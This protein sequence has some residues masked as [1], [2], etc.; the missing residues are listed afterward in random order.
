MNPFITQLKIKWKGRNAPAS[1]APGTASPPTFDKVRAGLMLL[2]I[3]ALSLMMSVH[4]RQDRAALELN[5]PSPREVRASR[6]V[7]YADSDKTTSLKQVAMDAARPVYDVDEHAAT[8]AH[9]TVQEIFGSLEATRSTLAQRAVPKSTSAR[10]NTRINN[11]TQVLPS[12]QSASGLPETYLRRLLTVPPTVFQRLRDTTTRLVDEAMDREIRDKPGE[13]T[14]A[15]QSVLRRAQET[16]SASQDARIVCAIANQALRPNH[17]LNRSKTQ[18]ARLAAASIVPRAYGRLFPGDKVIGLGETVHQDTLDKMTALGL[19]DPRQE[20]TTGF[21]ICLLAA[22]M[23]LLVAYYIAH[24]L[25]AL[26]QD[27]RRLALLS[28]IVMFSVAGLKIGASLL[29]LEFSGW[30]LGYLGMM[31]VTAAGML[32]SVLLDM[33][34]AMLIVALLS[35]QSGI[36]M[37]HEIRFSVMTLLSSLVGIASVTNV[38]VKNNLLSATAA[39]ALSN[40]GLVWLL[41]MLFNDRPAELLTG[42]AW[43]IGVAPFATFLFWFGVLALEKPFGILTHTALLEMSAFDRPLLKQLCAI[44]PGTYAHSMMVGTLAEAGAQAVGADA[45]L[46]RVGGYYHDIGKM[47]RPDFFIENQRAE[48]VHGRLSPS[49]SAL[50]I[51]AHVRD[52]IEMAKQHR[53]PAEIRDMI[54]QH[55][56]TTLISYFYR[57]ALADNGCGDCAPPGMEERFRYPGPKPQTRESAIV[58]L[59]DS[60]EAAARCIDKPNQEKLE[61]L[62]AG[63]VR[64]KIE[65]G[66]LDQ[67]ALTFADVK[68]ISNAFLHVLRAMMHGRIDY[69][70]DPPRTATGKPME[71]SRADLR[72]E[73][74]ALQ[75]PL[76]QTHVV[77]GEVTSRYETVGDYPF[78]T[79]STMDTSRQIIPAGSDANAL[80][81]A[82]SPLN[83]DIRDAHGMPTISSEFPPQINETVNDLGVSFDGDS[84]PE[85]ALPR[86]DMPASEVLYGR[87]FAERPITPAADNA[88]ST[89]CAPP[90]PI[91]RPRPRGGKRSAD[92]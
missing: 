81:L 39:L 46:C 51:T 45:L 74:P 86:L 85:G 58:M 29:G 90:A 73:P 40:V 72:P 18:A 61:A 41:G 6:S 8:K 52:G 9:D 20:L 60:V 77:A 37:N 32:V 33:H 2:T 79:D 78:T 82:P 11:I 54:A 12:M 63:I 89:G 68:H 10:S 23:V 5:K 21:A 16:L 83:L 59:A 44:A 28:V 36:I 80:P 25:P 49:L 1:P 56:G 22:V 43:A 24:A 50:I 31:S 42:S 27:T 71:V 55:H 3:A 62:I 38:R 65:D 7:I 26:Y 91:G 87:Q 4:L 70:K 47:N 34:L 66:Q 48:N 64:G 19:L 57:Q 15:Q 92:R 84:S 17:L 75:L 88:A 35:I 67:C 69:P 13:L 76:A 14:N 53:L 30:Q